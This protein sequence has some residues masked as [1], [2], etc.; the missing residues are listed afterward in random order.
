MMPSAAAGSTLIASLLLLVNGSVAAADAAEA[1]RVKV[2][3]ETG[4]EAQPEALVVFSPSGKRGHFPVGSTVLQAAR[5]LGVDIDSICGGRAL[6]CR[7]QVLPIEGSFSKEG[8]ESH[9]DHLSKLSAPEK[10]GLAQQRLLPAHRLSCQSR[11]LGDIRI[12]VPASSQ[13]HHPLV[14]KQ[15]EVRDVELDPVVRLYFVQVAEP[16]LAHSNGD[17]QQ[18]LVALERDWQLTGLDLDPALLPVLQTTLRHGRWQITVAVRAGRTI[19]ALWPDLHE[20]VFGLAV[21]VG[22]TTIAVYLCDLLSGDVLASSGS[23]NP[24]IRFGEDVMSRVSWAMLNPGGTVQLS[25]VVRAA[26]N[27]LAAETI[28]NAEINPADVLEITLVGNP[29][30]H[31]LLLGIDPSPLGVAPFALATNQ[32]VMISTSALGIDL[33]PCSK[34]YFLPC[35][36]GHVGADMAAVLLAEA[37]WDRDE[38]TLILDIGTNA[39]IVVGNRQRLLAASSP[40]GPAFEGAQISCGQRAAPGAIERVRIDPLT[41]EP[42]IKV[43]GCELWSDEAGFAEAAAEREVSGICGSGIIEAIASLFLAGVIR[44][45]GMIDPAAGERSVRVL[46]EGRICSYV[47]YEDAVSG[48]R[49]TISQ[50]DVRAIQLAKAALYAG[51]HLLMQCLGVG[52]V[53]RIRLAGAFGS[54]IDVKYAMVLGLIP[55]CSLQQVSAAGNAAGTGARLALLSQAARTEIEQR[56]RT[57]EKIETAVESSFQNYFVEAMEIPHRTHEFTELTKH[58]KLPVRSHKPHVRSGRRSQNRRKP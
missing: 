21:D 48:K 52:R 3:S 34:A 24:Q 9:P 50:T 36:A 10:R 53:D 22:S 5:K 28:R 31:H 32:A 7:C 54:H 11:V 55:D 58:F 12:D 13:V 41:L 49:I 26:I 1:E 8:M 4:T 56:V 33:H 17:L 38:I 51:T 15:F 30:M 35:I 14:R 16:V 20:Q 37:P 18:L 39:E 47:L 40:T 19:V 44:A 6:C 57:I 42:R 45:D 46:A 25:N 43:I 2:H 29:I 23:M 27:D